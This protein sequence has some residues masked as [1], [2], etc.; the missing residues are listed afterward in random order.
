MKSKLWI[1]SLD[2]VKKNPYDCQSQELFMNEALLL[3]D[4]LFIK[5]DKYQ[6]HFSVDERT[7]KKALWMLHLDILDTLRDCIDL[8]KKKKHRIVGKLFR[9]IQENIDLAT[10]FWE[11][12]R[13][14]PANLAKWYE[15]KVIPHRKFRQHLKNAKGNSAANYSRVIYEE[16]SQWPHHCYVKLTNSYVLGGDDGNRI[17]YDG[18]WEILIPPQTISQYTWLIKDS[19]LYFFS[20]VKSVGLIDWNEFTIFLNRTIQ[21]LVF[22]KIN[23]P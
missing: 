10:L 5:Y 14:N 21:G 17:I 20:N 3:L 13:S 9:D 18:H 4:E 19:I 8:L 1:Q 6:R 2:D 23:N 16:L 15:N 22:S 7:L 11:Q 12:R